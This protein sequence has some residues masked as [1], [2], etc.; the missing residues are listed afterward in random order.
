MQLNGLKVI[1]CD[2]KKVNTGHKGGIIRLMELDLN[3]GAF[4]PVAPFS[5][6]S[7]ENMPDNID[8]M[9]LSNYQQYLFHAFLAI[10]RCE[11]YSDLALRKPVSVAQSRWLTTA[12]RIS[13]LYVAKEKTI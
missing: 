7:V 12:G 13:R 6:I 10:S 3:S 1:G 11:C 9:V 2:G 8:R 4:V 5:S